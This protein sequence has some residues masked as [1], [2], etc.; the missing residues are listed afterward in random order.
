MGYYSDQSAAGPNSGCDI[1]RASFPP[2]LGWHEDEVLV[3]P[4]RGSLFHA[5]TQHV[6]RDPHSLSLD[7]ETL[8]PFRLRTLAA[9]SAAGALEPVAAA[10][11]PSGAG[12]W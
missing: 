3:T 10:E 1:S 5:E 7:D 6:G 4:K 8:L 2:R 9:M 11:T 12:K